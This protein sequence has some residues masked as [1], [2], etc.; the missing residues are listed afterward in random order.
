MAFLLFLLSI[1]LLTRTELNSASTENQV[2]SK[3]CPAEHGIRT[4]L[5]LP[6]M[7]S[8]AN[9]FEISGFQEDET[10]VSLAWRSECVTLR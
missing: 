6:K 9:A 3:K 1:Q 5:S 7:L 4:G 2:L 8:G 10:E